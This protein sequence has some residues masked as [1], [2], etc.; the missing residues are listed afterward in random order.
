MPAGRAV[1]RA[2]RAGRRRPRRTRATSRSCPTA[3][4]S[5]PS[6][7]AACALVHDGVLAPEPL[8]GWPVAGLEAGGLAGGDRASAVRHE[9]H[10]L[11]LLRQE[12]R[13]REDHARARAR[14]AWWAAS[15]QDVQE[16]FVT[17]AWIQGGPLAGRAVFGP[18]GMI[19][20]TINDHDRN[21]AID[22]PSVRIFAQHL[23][24]DVGKILRLRD[25]GSIPA[26]NPFVGREDAN[27]QIFTYGHRNATDF[28]WHPT[29]GELWATEIGPDGR[30]RAQHPARGT[31]LRLAARLARQALHEGRRLGAALVPR[32]HGDAVHLLDAV[33]QPE[34]ARLVHGRQARAVAAAICSSAR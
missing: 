16:V 18:D 22:D 34:H 4:R 17:D 5:S 2:P 12:Q 31:E 28:S 30:R 20:L 15:S 7:R 6:W 33:D 26:D 19:Y 11:S 13:R 24:S 14:A 3:M 25:D 32:G 23:D 29:T 1:P 8:A 9:P 27:P 21:N 10:R